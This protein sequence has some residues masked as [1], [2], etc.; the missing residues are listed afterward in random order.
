MK[1]G[2]WI[3]ATIALEKGL[4]VIKPFLV[5]SMPVRKV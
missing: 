1:P 4:Y 5:D 2:T 3:A